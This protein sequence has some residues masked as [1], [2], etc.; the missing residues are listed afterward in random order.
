LGHM[1][2]WAS[3]ARE[4]L[5][6][7]SL[8]INLMVSAIIAADPFFRVMTQ[9]YYREVSRPHPK[10]PIVR[11]AQYG[12]AVCPLPDTPQH[13]LATIDPAGRRNV[14]K[15]LRLG[16]HFSRI[17]YNQHLDEVTAIHQSAQLRQGR[18]LPDE[19]QA[20]AKPICDPPAQS[21]THDFPYFGVIGPDGRLVAYAGCLIAGELCSIERVFGHSSHLSDGIVPL[22]I[23]SIAEHTMR[24]HPQVRY[25]TYGTYYGASENLRRFKRKFGFTPHKVNWKLG[26]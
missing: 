15:A 25:Y 1:W 8:K 4:L 20:P 6:L 2:H 12:V 17:D 5:S 24:H 22:L 13:Y 9:R 26:S 21:P 11:K 16:Y 14:R 7:P 19:M 10:F 18:P 3:L 23:V